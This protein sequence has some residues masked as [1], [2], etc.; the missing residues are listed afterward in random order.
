MSVFQVNDYQMLSGFDASNAQLGIAQRQPL[1]GAEAF[2]DALMQAPLRVI[3]HVRHDNSIQ[4]I[5]ESLEGYIP[6]ALQDDAFY[7]LW[8]RDMARLCEFFCGILGSERVG[9]YLG[10][11]RGCR[12]YHIDNVPMRL[13]VTYAGQGTEWVPD[14]AVDR[15]A[16]L[17]G[18][19]NEKIVIDPS[20][21]EYMN[22]WDV[23]IFRGGS[24][25]LLHRTPDSALTRSSILMR[26]DHAGFWDSIVQQEQNSAPI[27]VMSA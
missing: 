11:E 13:L 25:G 16:F 9:F 6:R 21:R 26:L 15:N 18:E 1:E 23:A 19:E 20:K 3:A 8:I 22:K 12:R 24:K 10:T 17:S 2:F 5:E 27:K 7:P 14:Q 4:D